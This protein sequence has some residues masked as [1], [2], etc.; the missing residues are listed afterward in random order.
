M[1]LTLL[2]AFTC[3]ELSLLEQEVR[4]WVKVCGTL[5][6][7]FGISVDGRVYVLGSLLYGW[8]F[9]YGCCLFTMK[10]SWGKGILF[11]PARLLYKYV[12]ISREPGTP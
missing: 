10:T 4:V 12:G 1:R 8:I 3:W 5:Y 9:R 7:V 2:S 6:C 11:H